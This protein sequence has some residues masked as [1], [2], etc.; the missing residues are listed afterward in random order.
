M[1]GA[2]LTSDEARARLAK[3]AEKL[4]ERDDEVLRLR[5]KLDFAEVG[6]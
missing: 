1:A 6:L 3:L 5:T 2:P 4:S